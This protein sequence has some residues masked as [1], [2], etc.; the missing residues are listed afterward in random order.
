MMGPKLLHW[1]WH[2]DDPNVFE[3]AGPFVP[4]SSYIFHITFAASWLVAGVLAWRFIAASR[5]A[6]GA[7]AALVVASV[8]PFVLGV[9]QI[10]MV[11][12]IPHDLYCV[13]TLTCLGLVA[14]VYLAI[15]L[16]RVFGSRLDQSGSQAITR[17]ALVMDAKSSRLRGVFAGIWWFAISF[18]VLV[19]IA[20]PSALSDTNGIHQ[21]IATASACDETTPMMSLGG[22]VDKS[23]HL[24]LVD[25]A[26]TALA[27]AARPAKPVR[28][29]AGS[30][31]SFA[32]L[33][34]VP[35]AQCVMPQQILPFRVLLD[36]TAEAGAATGSSR[37]TM[38][39]TPWGAEGAA[40]SHWAM[41]ASVSVPM[42]LVTMLAEAA[43]QWEGGESL[44]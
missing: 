34:V 15:A 16:R 8:T 29:R 24:C 18:I 5:G 43:R 21:S 41:I 13:P 22:K 20:D 25:D 39:G 36:A 10:Q 11:Y 31:S 33:S 1:S 38:V 2:A 19:A 32:S 42:L 17:P 7:F 6:I 28:V 35:A 14:G 4:V 44:F 30:R 23:S 37:W 12:V 9:M 3:R 26:G 27:E 40:S